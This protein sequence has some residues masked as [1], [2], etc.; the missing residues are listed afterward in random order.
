[1]TTILLIPLSGSTGAWLAGAAGWSLAVPIG[2][3]FRGLLIGIALLAAVYATR[4]LL[5]MGAA[6]E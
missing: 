2:A 6:D 4:A 3:V 5:G 1:M